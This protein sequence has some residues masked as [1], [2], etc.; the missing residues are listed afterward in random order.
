MEAEQAMQEYISCIN[1]LDPEGSTKVM[2][3]FCEKSKL[4]PCMDLDY[5]LLYIVN[6]T[7]QHC[8]ILNSNI[9]DGV[10]QNNKHTVYRPMNSVG[11]Q[12]FHKNPLM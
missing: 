8:V 2:R 12:S 10:N 4:I 11:T 7:I 3:T 5:K 1:V 9:M 6:Y